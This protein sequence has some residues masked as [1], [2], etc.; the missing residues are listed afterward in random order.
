V[1]AK[2][3][4]V[5]L[6]TGL[7]KL[8]WGYL[9]FEMAFQ[10]SEVRS[11]NGDSRGSLLHLPDSQDPGVQKNIFSWPICCNPPFYY[12]RSSSRF[13]SGATLPQTDLRNLSRRIHGRSY[14]PNFQMAIKGDGTPPSSI[15]SQSAHSTFL[16]PYLTIPVIISSIGDSDER[17]TALEMANTEIQNCLRFPLCPPW[18]DWSES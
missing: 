12:F 7:F 3:N 14:S 2:R 11:D 13:H 8:D 4:G 18:M 10:I 5:F 9:V 17:S 6:A 1:T 16:K 15:C